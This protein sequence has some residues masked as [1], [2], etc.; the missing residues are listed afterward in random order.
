[1]NKRNVT[2]H[3][4]NYALIFI[5]KSAKSSY[6]NKKIILFDAAFLFEKIK[7]LEEDIYVC[8]N[9]I[10]ND[11]ET[12]AAQFTVIEAAG[13]LIKNEQNQ[14]LFIFR[15]NKWDLPKGKLDKGEK[16]EQAAVRECQEE[17]GLQDIKL[18]NFL[19][20]SYHV[21]LLGD[22]WVLKKTYWYH[23]LCNEMNLVPQKEEGITEVSW[24]NKTQIHSMMH[25]TYSNIAEVL[26]RAKLV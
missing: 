1:M 19:T 23:M 15:H 12:F 24:K 20:N 2:V 8:C 22:K 25:N 7:K 9:N 4:N 16:P 14:Y 6:E 26:S 13:G 17:C 21:Y 11:F 5:D 10:S 18:Q 3:F